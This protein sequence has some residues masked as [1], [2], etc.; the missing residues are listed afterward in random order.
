[1]LIYVDYSGSFHGTDGQKRD[2]QLRAVPLREEG[3]PLAFTV[4]GSIESLDAEQHPILITRKHVTALPLDG[5]RGPSQRLLE[6]RLM[7]WIARRE[8]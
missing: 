6:R 4:S 1:M 2:Y 5:L 7:Y 8:T 3:R